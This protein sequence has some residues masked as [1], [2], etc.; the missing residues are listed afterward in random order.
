MNMYRIPIT[1]TARGFYGRPGN[2]HSFDVPGA[3]ATVALGI[4]NEGRI[5]GHYV[6]D[7]VP[8][9]FICGRIAAASCF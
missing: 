9:A 8:H 7:G 6:A 5:V 2:L 3:G 4:N 1:A